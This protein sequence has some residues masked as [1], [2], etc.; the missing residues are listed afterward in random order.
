MLAAPPDQFH[1][2]IGQQIERHRDLLVIADA[3]FG[4]HHPGGCPL[5]ER[6]S[7]PGFKGSEVAADDGVIAAEALRRT[8]H[9]LQA[10]DRIERAQGLKRRQRLARRRIDALD[11]TLQHIVLPTGPSFPPRPVRVKNQ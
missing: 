3:G 1:R 7:G 9:A 2:G 5:D 8:S 6:C 10:G 4:Q 11:L